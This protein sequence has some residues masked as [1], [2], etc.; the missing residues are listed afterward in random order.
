MA[1]KKRIGI[2][3][4]GR[5]SNME[6]LIAAASHADYPAEIA[7]VLSN[8][9][10]AAGLAKAAGAGIPAEAID[11]KRFSSR[12][13]FEA[14]LDAALHRHGVEIVAC[15]GFMRVMTAQ[16][17]ERW[18]DRMLNIHPSLLPAYRGLDTHARALAD[19]VKLTGCT[20]HLVRP[21]LDSGPIIAQAAV[22]VLDGDTVSTLA[23]RILI[24]EHR[25]YPHALALFASGAAIVSGDRVILRQPQINQAISLYWPPLT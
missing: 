12:E 3:I 10:D 7:C 24:A 9:P 21:E 14:D 16:F 18:R 1:T 11:H 4:S 2:L 5:G 25:L 22:P 13:A 20:V 19:G 23:D 15:A 8:R 17:V 6:S